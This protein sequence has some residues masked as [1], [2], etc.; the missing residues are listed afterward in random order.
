[1]RNDPEFDKWIV[2]NRLDFYIDSWFNDQGHSLDC[3]TEELYK[4]FL[5]DKHVKPK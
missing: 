3:T 5:Q 4:Y 1:M 2:D